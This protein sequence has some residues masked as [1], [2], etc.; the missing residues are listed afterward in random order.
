MVNECG[1]VTGRL[2]CRSGNGWC[3]FLKQ[4]F[5]VGVDQR[6][7][8]QVISTFRSNAPSP[9]SGLLDED[10]VDQIQSPLIIRQHISP[11]RLNQLM[12]LQV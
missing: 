7:I 2:L 11:K 9:S 1:G 6:A 3:D 8:L 4:R 12:M 10:Q 5:T